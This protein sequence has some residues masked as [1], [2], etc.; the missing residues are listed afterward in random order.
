VTETASDG[1]ETKTVTETDT[2]PEGVTTAVVT[3]TASD[4]TETETVTETDKTVTGIDGTK[5]AV[6]VVTKTTPDGKSTRTETKTVTTPEGTTTAVAKQTNA[7]G[8]TTGTETVTKSDGSKSETVTSADGAITGTIRGADGETTITVSKFNAQNVKAIGTTLSTVS[9]ENGKTIVN[10]LVRAQVATIVSPA[11]RKFTIE[12]VATFTTAQLRGRARDAIEFVDT[13]I[14][15]V[16]SE[17]DPETLQ[18][19]FL[20]EL[21]ALLATLKDRDSDGDGVKDGVEL[22]AGTDPNNKD[23]DGD[24]IADGVELA[25]ATNPND[26]DSNR[27]AS[28]AE[29]STIKTIANR[30]SAEAKQVEAS[31]H[32][33]RGHGKWKTKSSSSSSSKSNAK[34]KSSNKLKNGGKAKNAKGKATKGSGAHI[35]SPHV[36]AVEPSSMVVAAVLIGLAA[37]AVV[38]STV[39][40]PKSTSAESKPILSGKTKPAVPSSSLV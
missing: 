8:L 14:E 3:E 12:V 23:S 37:A 20:E 34:S 35:R 4:G 10:D 31:S 27:G 38:V 11:Q 39:M 40:K 18:T 24:G 30:F 1:T 9:V 25:A 5:T 2:N 13:I 36:V 28:L 32:G 16:K 33:P 7:D 17:S 29:A 6:A 19:E 22:S 15:L 21:A 26:K